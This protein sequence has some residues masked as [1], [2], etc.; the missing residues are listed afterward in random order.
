MKI[1]WQIAKKDLFHVLKDRN[2]F[3]LLLIVPILLIAILGAVFSNEIGEDSKPSEFTVA[4]HNEDHKLIGNVLIKALQARHDNFKIN[5][6]DY[7][8]SAQ[9][10]QQ[11]SS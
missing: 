3:I 6:K 4:V 9:I 1:L 10:L 11:V 7:R 5:I 2:A 8:T